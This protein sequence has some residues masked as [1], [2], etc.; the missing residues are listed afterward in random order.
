[1]SFKDNVLFYLNE[2]KKKYSCNTKASCATK[3]ISTCTGSEASNDTEDFDDRL[4]AKIRKT[5]KAENKAQ[6]VLDD[7]IDK[8]IK[9]NRSKKDQDYVDDKIKKSPFGKTKEF[10]SNCDLKE[11]LFS[12]IL[13][14]SEN[15]NGKLINE[16]I[17]ERNEIITES[18]KNS[19]ASKSL[20]KARNK[21]VKMYSK[22]SSPEA[23]KALDNN[24]KIL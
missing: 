21:L 4:D 11:S 1:M 14:T 5:H 12:Q 16:S 17:K 3:K 22:I 13:N 2:E 23:K 7:F 24:K 20:I 15:I 18:I 9:N 8:G 6:E 10:D 19:S